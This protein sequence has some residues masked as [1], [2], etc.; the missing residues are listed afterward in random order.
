MKNEKGKNLFVG[1]A[2]AAMLAIPAC[3]YADN[4]ASQSIMKPAAVEQQ[5]NVSGVVKDNTGQP[6][7]GVSVIVKNNTRVGTVTNIDG[8]YQLSVPKGTTLVFSYVGYKSQEVKVGGGNLNVTL[9]EDRSNLEEVV[10]IGYGTMKKSDLTG[11]T[12]NVKTEA[13]MANVTGN[14]LEA[15]QGKAS[16]VA[17]FNNNK[18]GEGPAIRIRG[19]S[20]INASNEPLYVVDGFPLMSGDISDINPADIE[21]MEVLKDASAT[22]IYGSRGA[23]GVVMITTK[24]GKVGTKNLTFNSSVGTQ[25]PGRKLGIVTGQDFIDCMNAIYTNYHNDPSQAPFANGDTSWCTNPKAD[26]DWEDLLLRDHAFL[27]NYNLS[28]DGSANGTS[29]MLSGGYYNQNGLVP[30]QGYEKFSFHTNLRHQF[31]SWLTLGGSAQYTYSIRNAE[32]NAMGNVARYG[33]PTDSPYDA[34]GNLVV[35]KNPYVSDAWNPLI[36]YPEHT[37][38]TTTVRAIINAFAEAKILPEL[39][40]RISIGQDVRMNRGYGYNT[41]HLVGN[42]AKGTGSGSHSWNKGRSKLMEN[43]LTF[44]KQWDVHRFT[45]TAV[46]SWQDFDYQNTGISGSGFTVDAL[47]AWDITNA[48]RDTWSPSSSRYGNRLISYTGRITYAYNDKYLLTATARWDGSSRFGEDKKWGFFP[49]VGLAWR[50]SQEEF[51]KDNPVITDL[52]LRASFGVTGNQEIGNYKSLAQLSSGSNYIFGGAELVGYAQT[53]LANPNLQWERTNQWNFGFDLGLWNRFTVNFDYY[54]RDT[55]KLLYEVPLPRE[56]GFSTLLSN[57]GATQNKGWELTVGGNIFKNQD[58]YVDASVNLT[59]NTNK[60]KELYNVSGVETKE[61]QLKTDGTGIDRRLVV[62]KPV[63]GLYARHS[64]GIIKTQEQLDWYKEYVPKTASNASLGDEMYEDRDGNGSIGYEDYICIGS[65]QPK[66]FYGLNLNAGYKD[67]SISIYGQGGFKYASIAGA[68]S[69]GNNGTEWALSFSDNGSYLLWGENNIQ[70][71]L[72]FP[73]QYAY[74]RMWSPTNPDGDYPRPGSRGTYL[75]DR[76]NA[77]W[78]YFILKNIQLN[79]DF[80][81]LLKIKTVKALKVNLNFQNFVTFANHRGYNPVNGDISNP[82]S[83]AIIF[84]VDLKF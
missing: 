17:V 33:W 61:I 2:L 6:L 19:S 40:Y 80:T 50:I 18:P 70:E 39:T 36:D 45:A 25:M 51:L 59:Y 13:I 32:D 68:E 82:W 11:T 28:L 26:T 71:R 74:E 78:T 5:T 22:A 46:Y 72:Y 75:S 41:S 14:A 27:Q 12:S 1:L 9:Q 37:S 84:G 3:G 10:V 20:S 43:M 56:T 77:D 30:T 47:Q 38:R 35:P 58:W 76:T 23:N 49:S 44:A 42:M 81:K 62:G 16:G 83:K 63:D 65:V 52:K 79:Y 64:L 69:N 24:T 48:K 34:E 66:Y 55:N 57:V 29:Y 31:N 4:S 7:I 54:I 53:K 21:S 15:L 60:I 67:F 73:S 8:H